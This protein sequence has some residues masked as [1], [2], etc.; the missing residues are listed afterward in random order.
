MANP[1]VEG[2]MIIAFGAA[3]CGLVMREWAYLPAM[4]MA[5]RFK[6]EKEWNSDR[7][8]RHR[9]AGARVGGFVFFLLTGIAHMAGALRTPAAVPV[10][11]GG[12]ALACIV[13]LVVRIGQEKP[14]SRSGP[15]EP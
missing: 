1:Y 5:Q 10:I 14:S 4:K 13:T 2:A 7:V 6:P 11:L 15:E 8:I 3:M 9:I 12:S